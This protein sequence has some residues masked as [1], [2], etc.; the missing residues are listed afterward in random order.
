MSSP[1]FLD[2]FQRQNRYIEIIEITLEIIEMTL[3]IIEITVEIIE[4][5]LKLLKLL[6]PLNLRNSGCRAIPEL[7]IGR[8][9]VK[10]RAASF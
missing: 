9:D 4:I 5:T 3:E 8:L 6:P 1:I 10:F 7:R 2:R